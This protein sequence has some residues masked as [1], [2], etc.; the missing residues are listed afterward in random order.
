MKI[1]TCYKLKKDA[2]KEE[3]KRFLKEKDIPAALKLPYVKDYIQTEIQEVEGLDLDSEFVEIWDIE[4]DKETWLKKDWKN[5]KEFEWL[6]EI[7]K[8]AVSFVDTESAKTI[9]S[10][11]V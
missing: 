1:I 5:K 4:T 9:Y 6:K 3:F 10:V 11:Q 7:D 2:N 8:I